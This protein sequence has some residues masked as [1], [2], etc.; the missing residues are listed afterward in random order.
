MNVTSE[1]LPYGVDEFDAAKLEKAYSRLLTP[2]CAVSNFKGVPMVAESPVRFE[3]EYHST[4]RLPGNPP[5]GTVDIVIG[6]VVGVY[7]ADDV[8]NMQTGK[9]DVAKTQPIARCGY[10]DYAVV[11]ECFEMRMPG[12][13][14]MRAG[15]E[16]SSKKNREANQVNEQSKG[17]EG[18]VAVEESPSSHWRG[19][20]A[21]MS[22]D[23]SYR[24]QE[25]EARI[26]K[27]KPLWS[28]SDIPGYGTTPA[29]ESASGRTWSGNGAPSTYG[30][31]AV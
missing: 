30:S 13:D 6:K 23:S 5:M 10:Y 19:N 24:V 9:V 31:L 18:E 15:L 26:E 25:I 1:Q 8:I 16:G 17:T 12:A 3:C 20:S 21:P 28:E 14:I 2:K 22:Y 7:V 29:S 11:R 27:E 4:I